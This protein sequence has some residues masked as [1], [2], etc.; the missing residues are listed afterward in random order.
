MMKKSLILAVAV[1]AIYGVNVRAHC[2]KC[3]VGDEKATAEKCDIKKAAMVD[4]RVQTL[5]KELGL[6]ADQQAKVKA[7]VE[8]KMTEKCALHEETSKKMESISNTAAQE[9]RAV[10]TPEQAAKLDEMKKSGEGCCAGKA[11]KCAK[12]AAK[13]KAACCPKAG[14][15]GHI[16][17]MKKGKAACCP[18]TGGKT[19]K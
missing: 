13:D 12:C 1:V 9:I 8:K 19:K 15:K 14:E 17:P 16:C 18:L 10:L 7:A 11:E 5:T 4:D 3:G 6:S 2:G